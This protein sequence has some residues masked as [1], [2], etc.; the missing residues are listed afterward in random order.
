MRSNTLV[1]AATRDDMVARGHQAIGKRVQ[2]RWV[3][4]GKKE[5]FEWLDGEVLSYKKG[6]HSV[7]YDFD[8]PA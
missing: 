6:Q 4:V 5:R 7:K 3:K 1:V 8:E 2:V